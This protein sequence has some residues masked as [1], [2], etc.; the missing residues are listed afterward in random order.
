MKLELSGECVV[1]DI[2]HMIEFQFYPVVNREP[3]IAFIREM[4]F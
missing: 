2:G 1:K 3:I 4:H